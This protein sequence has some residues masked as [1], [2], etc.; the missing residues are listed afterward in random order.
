MTSNGSAFLFIHR[1]P[2]WHMIIAF[3]TRGV[4]QTGKED[5]CTMSN[6]KLNN[7]LSGICLILSCIC[8]Q[9]ATSL[10]KPEDIAEWERQAS[11]THSSAATPCTTQKYQ[12]FAE[13][14]QLLSCPER[15]FAESSQARMAL[16]LIVR[17]QA[18]PE[19]KLGTSRHFH[20]TSPPCRDHALS[21]AGGCPRGVQRTGPSLHDHGA[22]GCVTDHGCRKKWELTSAAD[23]TWKY[24]WARGNTIKNSRKK[25]IFLSRAVHLLDK[26]RSDY[27]IVVYQGAR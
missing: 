3:K 8:R 2:R 18:S 13:T 26:W 22:W 11:F 16:Q 27:T 1:W 19:E 17:L 7:S 12:D 10:W 25:K 9:R 5:T 24:P 21:L 20:A 6:E 4:S 14:T 23:V 15:H